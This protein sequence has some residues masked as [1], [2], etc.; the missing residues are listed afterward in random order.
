MLAIYFRHG[1]AGTQYTTAHWLI[2][3]WDVSTL[4]WL[5]ANGGADWTNAGG[6]YSEENK[7]TVEYTGTSSW[8]EYDVTEIVRKFAGGTPNYG[9][10]IIPDE[11]DGNT[12]RNYISSDNTESVSL[13]PKL[14]ITY[15]TTAI[16][17]SINDVVGKQNLK[18]KRNGLVVKL[19]VPFED[20][21]Q[22]VLI[23]AFGRAIEVIK[24]NGK[25]W[26]AINSES[27]SMGLY[28]VNVISGTE[29]LTGKYLHME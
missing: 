12:G 29:K 27:L 19:F 14:T 25:K 7:T 15:E 11:S 4:T 28:F 5:K 16:I 18:V 1:T 13:R 8:E 26:H 20:S 21:Y 3:D 2:T 10:F 17:N 22:I 6:D 9:F 24:G 23:D